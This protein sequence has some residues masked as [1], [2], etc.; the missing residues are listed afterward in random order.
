[1][2]HG[3][4]CSAACGIFLDQGSNPGLEEFTDEASGPGVFIVLI[5]DSVSLKDTGLL[6]F[7]GVF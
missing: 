5:M 6:R 1:M 7:S 2:V 3:L 4:S